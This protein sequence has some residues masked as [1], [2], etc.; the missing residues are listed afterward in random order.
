MDTHDNKN[1]LF[2]LLSNILKDI[3]LD[4]S[5][6]DTFL[7]SK[8]SGIIDSLVQLQLIEMELLL[9]ITPVFDGLLNN[10]NLVANIITLNE[11][12]KDNINE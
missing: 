8:C 5:R 1:K 11:F 12:I 7:I 3:Q 4:G 10:T 9:K 2:I 6:Q